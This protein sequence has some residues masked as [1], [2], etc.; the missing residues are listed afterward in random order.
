MSTK[1][2]QR[3]KEFKFKVA[4][5]AVKGEK[6]LSELASEY[7]VH[8][9]QISQWKKQLLDNGQSVFDNDSSAEKE[10]EAQLERLYKTV[11]RQQVT[12]EFLKKN[13]GIKE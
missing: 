7:K 1:R 4:L 9:N 11:G 6:Q 12:I 8:A 5:E 10:K 13:L 3:T 2:V